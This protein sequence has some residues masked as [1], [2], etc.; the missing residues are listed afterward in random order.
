MA[1]RALAIQAGVIHGS[2][3]KRDLAGVAG[4]ALRRGRNVIRA[5]A[6]RSVVVV[7]GGAPTPARGFVDILSVAPGD[8]ARV[9]GV[10]LSGRRHVGC[11][12]A[13]SNSPI[14]ANRAPTHR[15]GVV[16]HPLGRRPCTDRVADIA[17]RR[18]RQVRRRFA[19]RL[20]VVVA[21]CALPVHVRGMTHRRRGPGELVV[22]VAAELRRRKGNMPCGR[23]CRRE[24]AARYMAVVA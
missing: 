13:R 19:G 11:R 17:A 14:V 5:L 20:A 18:G 9:A 24:Q 8:R 16:H 6:Y 1:G 3:C 2:R 4:I 15:R 23:E 7:A 12:F 10:A 21:P 22:A